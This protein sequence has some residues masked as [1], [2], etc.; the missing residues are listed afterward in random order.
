MA[1]FVMDGDVRK[2]Y[3]CTK[4]SV[5][6]KGMQKK[7]IE[8][9]IIAAVIREVKRSRTE[10]VV[11]GVTRTSPVPRSRSVPQ[12]DPG[13]PTYFNLALDIP[14]GRFIDIAQKKEWG[15]KVPGETFL[16][17]ILFADNYWLIA[18]SAS[19]FQEMTETWLDLL[20]E[21]GWGAPATEL[22][23]ATTLRDEVFSGTILIEGGRW[24][25]LSGQSV[26]RRW[27]HT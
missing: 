26:L 1:L 25:G 20:Q 6:I 17:L 13:M 5:V 21:Y 8:D 12:G 9:I 7:S 10:V 27:V 23:W 18:R 11:D 24:R 16:S 14:A 3:D 19:V 15:W 4:H 22:T 2:A